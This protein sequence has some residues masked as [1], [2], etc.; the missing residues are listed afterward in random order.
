MINLTS[1]YIIERKGKIIKE[2]MI[3]GEGL[4]HTIKLIAYQGKIY[5]LNKHNGVIMEC[6]YCGNETS[7]T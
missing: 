4:F 5:W 6:I 1:A 3:Y 7:E 2:E